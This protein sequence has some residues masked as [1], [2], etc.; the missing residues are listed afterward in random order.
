[1][2]EVEKMHGRALQFASEGLIAMASKGLRSD[3]EVVLAAVKE[4]VFALRDASEE[5]RAD[6]EVVVEAVRWQG[7]FCVAHQK[8]FSAMGMSCFM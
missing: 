1:M 5:L 6:L 8:I 3:R 4:C 7:S 2:I